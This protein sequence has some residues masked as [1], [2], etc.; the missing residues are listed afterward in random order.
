ME[1]M[2]GRTP[3]LDSR[4]LLSRRNDWS[5]EPKRSPL[6]IPA[7]LR[8]AG[9]QLAFALTAC[10]DTADHDNSGLGDGEAASAIMLV[11]IANKHAGRYLDILIHNATA[12]AA[13]APDVYAGEQNTA[14]DLRIAVDAHARRKH[15]LDYATAA[16]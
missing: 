13:R 14:L 15:A 5:P 16:H 11:V 10:S 2:A 9:Q 4:A 12:Q 3:F 8:R 7:S 6:Y 1:F